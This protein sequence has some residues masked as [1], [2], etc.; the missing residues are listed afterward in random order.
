MQMYTSTG[1]FPCPLE[2]AECQ[3]FLASEMNVC[4][5]FTDTGW[6]LV[7]SIVTDDLVPGWVPETYL[8]AKEEDNFAEDVQTYLNS[9]QIL[10]HCRYYK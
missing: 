4:S 10:K 1:S 7:G 6:W 2:H 5:V 8:L 3:H 9:E